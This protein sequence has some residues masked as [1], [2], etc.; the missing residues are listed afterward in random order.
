MLMI[1]ENPVWILNVLDWISWMDFNQFDLL[2]SFKSTEKWLNEGKLNN[3]AIPGLGC[4]TYFLQRPAF[5]E[6][7]GPL[8]PGRQPP[9][10]MGM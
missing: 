3:L 1:I 5:F 8:S 10:T 4:Q 2:A 9:A 7:W 6:L